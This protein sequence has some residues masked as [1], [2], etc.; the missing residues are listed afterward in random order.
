MLS[1]SLFLVECLSVQNASGCH[2]LPIFTENSS[3]LIGKESQCNQQTQETLG[4]M[5]LGWKRIDSV[6]G[7]VDVR[8]R[9]CQPPIKCSKHVCLLLKIKSK[10]CFTT[11]STINV[12]F[13]SP[14]MHIA[15]GITVATPNT[16]VL[17]LNKTR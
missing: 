9:R 17:H 5:T 3:G 10:N 15:L 8:G 2:P 4:P 1:V 11:G 12:F 13:M 16:G 14:R 7:A 6:S